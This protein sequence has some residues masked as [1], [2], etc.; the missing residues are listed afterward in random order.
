MN[1]NNPSNHTRFVVA[2]ITFLGILCVVGGTALVFKGY[3]GDLVIGGGLAAI[4]GLI[5][6]L[7]NRTNTPQQDVTISGNPPKVEMT[8]PQTQPEVKP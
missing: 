4:S 2:C 5:G 7:S 8:Q 6:M 1:G 3:P